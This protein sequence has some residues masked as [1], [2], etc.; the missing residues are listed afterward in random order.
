MKVQDKG[1]NWLSRTI[2]PKCVILL[3]HY[4]ST[5]D[6]YLSVYARCTCHTANH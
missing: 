2:T 4:S 1:Y 3:T 6:L 5:K